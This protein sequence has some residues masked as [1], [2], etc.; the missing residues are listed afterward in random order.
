MGKLTKIFLKKQKYFSLKEKKNFINLK[1][2]P[3]KQ[4]KNDKK[5]CFLPYFPERVDSLL[6][7]EMQIFLIGKIIKRIGM[8]NLIHYQYI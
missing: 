2:K 6:N 1:K 3:L 4:L 7:A 5:R 8:P